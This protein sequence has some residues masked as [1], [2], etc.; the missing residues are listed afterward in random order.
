[1]TFAP[2]LSKLPAVIVELPRTL[3]L[4]G[5]EPP[6]SGAPMYWRLT[7][8]ARLLGLDSETLLADVEAGRV[9]CRVARFGPRQLVHL[10]SGDVLRYLQT[11]GRK[12]H[13]AHT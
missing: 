10:H 12:P 8:V 4:A 13:H 7:S 6:P 11:L 2:T 5:I 1:V 3:A 9:P